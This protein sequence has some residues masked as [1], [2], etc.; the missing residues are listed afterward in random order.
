[1]MSFPQ[2]PFGEPDQVVPAGP[3]QP[4]GFAICRQRLHGLAGPQIE[5]AEQIV[6]ILAA[7]MFRHR[8]S[9]RPFHEFLAAQPR[10]QVDPVIDYAVLGGLLRQP[11][12]E[13][14]YGARD[15]VRAGVDTGE[16]QGE[17][18]RFFQSL[19]SGEIGLDGQVVRLPVDVQIGDR[20]HG[21]F[22][23]WKA[24]LQDPDVFS[25]VVVPADAEERRGEPAAH[26][27][28]VG[29]R[30]NVGL[31]HADRPVKGFQAKVQPDG[32]VQ[33]GPVVRG[34]LQRALVEDEGPFVLPEAFKAPGLF[35]PAVRIG[36]PV[37][38][39]LDRRGKEKMGREEGGEQTGAQTAYEPRAR[40]RPID[41]VRSGVE[42]HVSRLV[43][44]GNV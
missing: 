4:V 19:P 14:P 2:R 28:I 30:F 21:R 7:A 42:I 5:A 3:V 44:D 22:A 20:A 33:G 37:E 38:L 26:T 43:H 16:R 24:V 34:I 29:R 25:G 27:Y 23:P 8:R 9:Q 10:E 36:R 12:H 35:D 17:G 39:S 40:R 1:M 32:A 13:F 31:E 15:V 6:G 11:A 18:L 41:A